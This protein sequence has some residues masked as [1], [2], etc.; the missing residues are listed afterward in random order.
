M[1]TRTRTSLQICRPPASLLL[2][3]F[4][5]LSRSRT[6]ARVSLSFSFSGF[7]VHSKHHLY[8]SKHHCFSLPRVSVYQSWRNF[9]RSKRSASASVNRK[10]DAEPRMSETERGCGRGRWRNGGSGSGSV[11]WRCGRLRNSRKNGSLLLRW[12]KWIVMIPYYYHYV[13]CCGHIIF[14]LWLQAAFLMMV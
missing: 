1:P 13:G 2:S 8:R 7:F 11:P 14:Q 4:L 12:I 5:S 9:A 10:G 6:R 3:L